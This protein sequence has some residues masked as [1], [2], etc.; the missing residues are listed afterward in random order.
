MHLI[1]LGY[2]RAI[3]PGQR[4][5]LDRYHAAVTAALEGL[6]AGRA[7]DLDVARAVVRARNR[8]EA[9]RRPTSPSWSWGWPIRNA[10]SADRAGDSAALAG[11]WQK[12]AVRGHRFCSATWPR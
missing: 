1:R 11:A 4:Q 9:A 12:L 8:L 3:N 5:M 6:P 7:D 2:Q 10:G